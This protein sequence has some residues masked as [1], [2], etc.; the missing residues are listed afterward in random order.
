MARTVAVRTT[1]GGG[2]SAASMRAGSRAETCSGQRKSISTGGMGVAVGV[3]VGIGVGDG[4]GV[5]VGAGWAVNVASGEDA[6]AQ[7]ANSI[8][9]RMMGLRV[10]IRLRMPL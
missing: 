3:G 10:C 7:P 4:K 2:M 1:P 6:D 5:P 8:R 9:E